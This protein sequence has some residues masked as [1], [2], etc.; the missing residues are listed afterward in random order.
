MM[1]SPHS[2]HKTDVEQIISLNITYGHPILIFYNTP[3]WISIMPQFN[4]SCL[5]KTFLRTNSV[6]KNQSKRKRVQHSSRSLN[7]HQM[8]NMLPR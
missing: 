6:G 8:H 2:Y 4:D 7:W 1:Q 5:I 3:P